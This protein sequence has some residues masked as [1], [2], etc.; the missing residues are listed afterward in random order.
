MFPLVGGISRPDICP[1]NR[2]G[3]WDKEVLF[4]EL[5]GLLIVNDLRIISLWMSEK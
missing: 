1:N 4:D 5:R 2:S 3:R